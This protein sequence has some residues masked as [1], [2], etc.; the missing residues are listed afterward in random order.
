M[1][2]V[3]KEHRQV[4]LTTLGEIRDV[5]SEKSTSLRNDKHALNNFVELINVLE[6]FM[7]PYIK[8]YE[9]LDPEKNNYKYPPTECVGKNVDL[10]RSG[11]LRLRELVKIAHRLNLITVQKVSDIDH[12]SK[13][14][15]DAEKKEDV[16]IEEYEA[17]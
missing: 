5:V 17:Y 1:G 10:I 13:D 6:D 2:I 9:E 15:E 14:Q 11:H 16:D 3:E 7:W 4:I 8:N 12:G